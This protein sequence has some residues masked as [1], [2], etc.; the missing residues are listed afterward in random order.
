MAGWLPCAPAWEGSATGGRTRPGRG[1]LGARVIPSTPHRGEV[2]WAD[3]PGDKVRPVLVLTRERFIDRLR[4]VLVAPV[5][6]TVRG[7]PTEV[8]LGPGDGLP[9]RCAANFDNLFTL[10]RDR[11]RDRITQLRG[12]D[13]DRVCEA[14]RFAAGC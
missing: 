6:T 7:I 13:L 1:P 11:L 9:Q 4:A 14:Y 10:R 3:V 12:E 8:E 2:W 5:T